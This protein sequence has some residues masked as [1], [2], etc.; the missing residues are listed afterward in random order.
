MGRGKAEQQADPDG[1]PSYED[2]INESVYLVSVMGVDLQDIIRQAK[3]RAAKALVTRPENIY[4]K[5][6]TPLTLAARG[7][8]NDQPILWKS[9]VDCRLVPEHLRIG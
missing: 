1:P 5:H 2:D 9:T 6:N 7:R 3:E 8:F 4:I